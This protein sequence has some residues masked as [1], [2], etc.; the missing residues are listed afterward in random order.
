MICFFPSFLRFYQI[1]NIFTIKPHAWSGNGNPGI[2][3]MTFFVPVIFSTLFIHLANGKKQ[4]GANNNKVSQDCVLNLSL[5]CCC[6]L[7]VPLLIVAGISS[8]T[9]KTARN[10]RFKIYHFGLLSST[11]IA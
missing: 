7:F 2:L 3:C 11:R 10:S 1:G 4:R 8:F 5:L 9:W 6:S